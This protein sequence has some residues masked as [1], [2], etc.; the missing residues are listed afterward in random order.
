MKNFR[1]K[2]YTTY[3]ERIHEW[4]SPG[5][6][7]LGCTRNL[8]EFLAQPYK[9]AIVDFSS[10]AACSYTDDPLLANFNW[11]QI[12]LVLIKEPYWEKFDFVLQT[13]VNHNKIKNFLISSNDYQSNDLRNLYYPYWFLKPALSSKIEEIEYTDRKYL[14]DALLGSPR[15]NKFFLIAKIVSNPEILEQSLVTF[16]NEFLA[17][18]ENFNDYYNHIKDNRIKELYDNANIRYPY[19]SKSMDTSLENVSGDKFT[20]SYFMSGKDIPWKIYNTTWYSLCTETSYSIDMQP[21]ETA[22]LTERTGRM[23]LAK[24]IFVMF[25]CQGTL[26][27]L[28]KLGFKTF[29]SIIDES[30]DQEAD[31]VVRMEKAFQQVELLARLNPVE[32]YKKTTDIREHNYQRMFTLIEELKNQAN[33]KLLNLI[34]DEFFN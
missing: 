19:I 14:F 21:N 1:Y 15:E 11:D 12:D 18:G 3:S 13:F 5:D 17:P 27:L 26:D 2:I 4:Q 20:L 31:A 24:R 23:F 33:E 25:G 6:E 34:P 10:N 16:R 30:Y 8:Q 29:D 32:V 7:S 22:K 28:H 9:I